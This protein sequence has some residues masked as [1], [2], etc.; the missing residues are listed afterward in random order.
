MH[1][2]CNC[3]N[4]VRSFRFLIYAARV[5]FLFKQIFKGIVQV[6]GTVG[7]FVFFHIGALWSLFVLSIC[8]FF[9][10]S[11][12]IRRKPYIS[13][14]ELHPTLQCEKYEV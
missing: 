14:V 7:W 5:V 2:D 12:C 11:E 4:V 8:V 13:A 10:I 6:T 9:C 1:L 3:H